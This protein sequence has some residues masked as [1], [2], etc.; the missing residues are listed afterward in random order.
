[1][2]FY[3]ARSERSQSN[4]Y[5]RGYML[6][7][8]G[9]PA[10]VPTS[11]RPFLAPLSVAY[12]SGSTAQLQHQSQPRKKFAEHDYPANSFLPGLGPGS[13]PSSPRMIYTQAF[14]NEQFS[15]AVALFSA[16]GL[17]RTTAGFQDASGHSTAR[18]KSPCK[19]SN[20]VL[21]LWSWNL[22]VWYIVYMFYIS[23]T[24]IFDHIYILS[25]SNGY[26]EKLWM[27]ASKKEFA[28]IFR[29]YLK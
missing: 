7:L 25:V 26:S 23:G 6:P 10:S 5:P 18:K 2:F 1:M 19:Y 24:I 20:N 3:G 11:S 28:T 22:L 13:G 9:A 21:F 29:I 17:I 27:F 8:F 16:A 12:S 15:P 4:V 14:R